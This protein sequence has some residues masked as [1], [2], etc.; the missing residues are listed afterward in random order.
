LERAGLWVKKAGNNR[1]VLDYT[2]MITCLL[3][4]GWKDG[5]PGD[6]FDFLLTYSKANLLNPL[7]MQ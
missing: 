1:N 4:Q 2:R 3:E 7:E 5:L 6:L